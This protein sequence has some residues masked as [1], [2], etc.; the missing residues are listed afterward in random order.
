[1]NDY[2]NYTSLNLQHW[3]PTTIGVVDCSF[4]KDIKKDYQN[5]LKDFIYND[6]GFSYTLIHKDKNFKILN[7]W[8]TKQV[9][10]YTKLHRYPDKYE[11]NQSWVIDYKKNVGQPWH[12]HKGCTLS[13]VY[14]FDSTV[15]DKGTKFRSPYHNDV[16][17]PLNTTPLDDNKNDK[18]NVLTFP[19]C[20]Y[21]PVEGRLLIFRS[22]IEHCMDNKETESKRVIFS[23]NFDKKL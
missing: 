3:F 1:M 5:Y 12:T 16:S 8:I 20:S 17:N 22:Y 18:Y 2:G 14:Y 10:E 4:H 21:T 6:K 9:N 7:D 19:S 15:D 13:T 11:A 23:Y